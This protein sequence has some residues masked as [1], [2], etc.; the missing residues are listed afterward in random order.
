MIGSA[1]TAFVLSATVAGV[2]VAASLGIGRAAA[3]RRYPNPTALAVW[4]ATGLVAWLAATAA[5]AES[6]SLGV[7]D[8]RPPREPLLP[9]TALATFLLCS[10]TA[11]FRDLL[12]FIPRWQPVLLQAFRLGVEFAFWRLHAEGLAPAQVTLEGRNLDVLVGLSAPL[13]AAG[14]ASG[15]IGPRATIA[16]NLFG[17]AML[18]NAIGTTATS[19][20]GPAHLDWPGEPFTAIAAWPV[21]WIPAFLAPAAFFLHVVSIR[22]S[23]SR[24]ATVGIST[25]GGFTGGPTHVEA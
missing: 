15:R 17:L 23:L 16:W 13:V 12:P 8:A 1:G 25:S 9:L 10:T 4:V 20:P 18:L 3:R 22:Q 6:G 21:V 14:I 5:L 2:I 24:L 7:W 11:T 19:V